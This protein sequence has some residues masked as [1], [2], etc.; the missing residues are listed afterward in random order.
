MRHI[1]ASSLIWGPYPS[2]GV[3]KG[4]PYG[5]IS[6]YIQSVS[7]FLK[8]VYMYVCMR[9]KGRGERDLLSAGLVP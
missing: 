4:T 7:L 1:I 5:Y 8:N 2:K 3:A 6:A 9:M